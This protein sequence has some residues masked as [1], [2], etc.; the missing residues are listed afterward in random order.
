[1]S[2]GS[3][4]ELLS[5]FPDEATVPVGWVRK[6]LQEPGPSQAEG[7]TGPGDLRVEDVAEMYDR[8]PAA[9]RTWCRDGRLP[10]AYRLRGRE[11]R[12]PRESLETFRES[13]PKKAGGPSSTPPRRRGKSADLGAW[14]KL[15]PND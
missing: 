3:L 13:Q 2:T 11:W 9:V 10:G 4:L 15:A 6:H 8:S 5:P 1:M 7:E 12:I 14:R